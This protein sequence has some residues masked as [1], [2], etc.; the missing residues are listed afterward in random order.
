MSLNVFTNEILIVY[1]FSLLKFSS[2]TWNM[3]SNML[4]IHFSSNFMYFFHVNIIYSLHKFLQFYIFTCV[5][6]SSKIMMDTLSQVDLYPKC[7]K[8]RWV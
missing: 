7:S 2:N 5:K 6:L 1:F 8:Y 3:V 4:P